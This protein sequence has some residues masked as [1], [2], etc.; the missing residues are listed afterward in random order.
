MRRCV[1]SQIPVSVSED[2]TVYFYRV[3]EYYSIMNL[4]PTKAYKITLYNT[5]T[6]ARIVVSLSDSFTLSNNNNYY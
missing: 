2:M 4:V 6:Y 1:V 3:E 5:V